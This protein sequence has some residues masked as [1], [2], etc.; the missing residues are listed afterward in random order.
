MQPPQ[1][2]ILFDQWEQCNNMI[3]SWILNSLDPDITQSVIY[4][5]TAKSL[6]DELNHRYGQSNGAR[7][8]EVQKDLSYVSQGSY[9]VG[10]YFNNVKRL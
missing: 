2:S 8:Y 6:G 7:M 9:D 3:I 10:G 5:K 4:S 1:N